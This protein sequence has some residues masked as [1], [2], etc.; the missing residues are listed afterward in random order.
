MT[1]LLQKYLRFSNLAL[2]VSMFFVLTAN[3]A[4]GA[5]SFDFFDY[6]ITVVDNSGQPLPGGMFTLKINPLT[7]LQILKV[8]HS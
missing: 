6:E 7:E 3:T 4:M 5:N 2:A 1:G 8:N